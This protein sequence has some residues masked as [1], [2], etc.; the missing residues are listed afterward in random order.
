MPSWV[1]I[2]NIVC[3][4]RCCSTVTVDET[5][6]KVKKKFSFLRNVKKKIST[7]S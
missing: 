2:K 1:E 3:K 6:S 4:I 5:D 7:K